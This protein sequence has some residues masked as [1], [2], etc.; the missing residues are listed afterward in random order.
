MYHHVKTLIYTVN[1]GD[2]APCFGNMLLEQFGGANA[3]LA[4]AMRY[5]IQ[6]LNCEELER[7]HMLHSIF[8]NILPVQQSSISGMCGRK[9]CNWCCRLSSLRV[10]WHGVMAAGGVKVCFKEDN[11]VTRCSLLDRFAGNPNGRG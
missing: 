1:V 3:E 11:H 9:R 6:G 7:K 8:R 2:A 10:A 4:A 5:T